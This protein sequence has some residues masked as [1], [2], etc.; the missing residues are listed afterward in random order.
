LTDLFKWGAWDEVERRIRIRLSLY[1]NA[2][3]IAHT[4]MVNDGA[5]DTLAMQ[6]N[7]SIITGRYD[8]WW[9]EQFKPYTGQWIHNHPDLAGVARLYI[10]LK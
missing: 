5:F 6:S 9:R 3:E 1:A 10:R 4:P 2:Y 7:P 8:D